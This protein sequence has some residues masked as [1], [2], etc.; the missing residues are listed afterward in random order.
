VNL[1]WRGPVTDPSGYAAG[2][3]VVAPTDRKRVVEGKRVTRG[4]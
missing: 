3:A 4:V 1:V 2:D